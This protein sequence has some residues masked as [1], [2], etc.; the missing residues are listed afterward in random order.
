[1]ICF[2]TQHPYISCYT[3]KI[4]AVVYSGPLQVPLFVFGNFAG[5]QN[6]TLYSNQ[7]GQILLLLL[8]MLKVYFISVNNHQFYLLLCCLFVSATESEYMTFQIN[9]A[10]WVKMLV[11]TSDVLSVV[12]SI[13]WS[14]SAEKNLPW[15]HVLTNILIQAVSFPKCEY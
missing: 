6:Q 14:G 8:S 9:I 5:V 3:H 10:Q 13:P 15:K 2:S 4:L 12:S 11:K 1:M 7:Q